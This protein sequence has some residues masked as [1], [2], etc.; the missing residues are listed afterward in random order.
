MQVVRLGQT[1]LKV[2]RIGL[3][4]WAFSGVDTWGEQDRSDAIRTVH[5]A[6]DAGINFFDTAEAYG[7]GES[8]QVL[9]QALA[10]RRHEAII[11][12]KVRFANLRRA[13]LIA[14]CERSLRNL[15][16]DVIDLYQVHWPNREVDIAETGAALLELQKQ[17]KIRFIGVSNFGVQD[18]QEFIEHCPCATDQVPYNLLW[19]AI[20]YRILPACLE[21]NIGVLAYSPL[22]QGLLTGKFF[23]AED[24]PEER[25]RTRFFSPDR[26]L[27]RHGDQGC[28]KEVFAAIDRLRR[29]CDEIGQPMAK[30]ALAW[31]LYQPGVTAVLAGA[32]KPEQLRLNADADALQLDKEL[33]DQMDRAA[34]E[35]KITIGDNPDMWE[36]ESRY[37]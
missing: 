24:V 37:R 7:D 5:A 31:L 20:E 16:T 32:R 13:D 1:D 27:A 26:P 22:A 3:G 12:S 33:L 11:A 21:H 15:R 34:Q 9:G 10:G 29:I 14:A 23:S 25:R 19:R 8:E 18:L 2:S 28:E 35:I 30:T 6:L 17:G 36:S 4:C